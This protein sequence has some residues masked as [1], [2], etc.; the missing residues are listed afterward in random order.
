MI[1]E[2]QGRLYSTVVGSFPYRVNRALIDEADWREVEAIKA[3]SL[4]ALDFQLECGVDFPSDGQFFDMVESY[5]KPLRAE[6]FLKDDYSIGDAKPPKNHPALGLDVELE[7]I[8]K[9]RG[10]LGLRVP[11]T[12]PFTLGYRIKSGGRSVVE[13]GDVDGLE[14]V[15]EAVKTYCRSFNAGLKGSIISVDEPVLPF[16]LAQFKEDFIRETLD[17]IFESVD[18]NYSCMHVCGDVRPIKDL[19]LS[20]DVDILDH[21]FEGTDNWG[22]YRGRELVSAEKLLSFGLVNTNTHKMLDAEGNVIVESVEHIGRRL[23]A[24]AERFGVE[25]LLVSPDCGFGGMK[26]L[27]LEED[28]RW[29]IIREK[30]TNMISARNEYRDSRPSG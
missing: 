5:V 30:L 2:L 12:G 8:L 23:R 18:R 29:R 24:A 10:G 16:V 25:N 17:W 4:E 14:R 9:S 27:K 6:G 28:E 1:E 11:V 15:A 22:V 3:I 13:S 7:R 26:S 19:A 21:E 20:L